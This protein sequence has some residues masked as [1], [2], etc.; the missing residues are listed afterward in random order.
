MKAR[1]FAM[2]LMCG[3]AAV[4]GGGCSAADGAPEAEHVGSSSQA[5]TK[6]L[7]LISPT[8][9]TLKNNRLSG[10][11]IKTQTISGAAPETAVPLRT[12]IY[13][14]MKGNCVIRNMDL[15]VKFT[16]TSVPT[17]AAYR[18][19]DMSAASDQVVLRRRGGAAIT[20]LTMTDVGTATAVTLFPA[21]CKVSLKIVT[22][23]V[24]VDSTEEAEEIIT[25]LEA[26]LSKKTELRET[27]EHLMQ[28]SGAFGF[29][30]A[31]ADSFRVELTNE[32]IQELRAKASA[33]VDSIALLSSACDDMMTDEDRSNMMLLMLGLPQLGAPEDWSNPDG[34]PKTLEEFMGADSAAIYATVDKLVKANALGSGES[35]ESLYKQAALDVEKAKAKLALAKAQLAD[36]L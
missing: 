23:E 9:C 22:N 24:D 33:A 11:V 7:D 10:C 28:F 27:Y 30:Q 36:W 32:T 8:T 29:L 18:Y 14:T 12:T 5:I 34:S 35:Y 15:A 16:S 19:M 17:V 2:T 31:V 20:S 1:F 21:D 25:A 13:R 26:D 3:S 4:F 6:T